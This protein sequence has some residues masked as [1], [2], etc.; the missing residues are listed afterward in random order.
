MQVGKE[1][2]RMLPYWPQLLLF[3]GAM[4]LIALYGLTVSGH[5][6]AEFR[7]ETLKG[8]SGAVALWLS[9]AV[10]ASATGLTLLRGWETLPWYAVVIGAG[11]MLLF[12]PLLL[13]PLPDSFVNGRG[14][15]VVFSGGAALLAFLLWRP[16]V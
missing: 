11:A 13:R 6:P 9:I 7:G 2:M 10:A 4:M 3:M 16:L 12:A 14:G 1:G 5:F 15:L 8:G